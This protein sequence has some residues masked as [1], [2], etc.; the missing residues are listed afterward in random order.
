V[1][2]HDNI[3]PS[4]IFLKSEV[5]ART[6]SCSQ[7]RWKKSAG[8]EKCESSKLERKKHKFALFPPFAATLWKPGSR[9]QIHLS[10]GKS[11]VLSKVYAC[12]CCMSLLHVPVA[13]HCCM[14]LRHVSAAFPCCLFMLHVCSEF[15]CFMSMLHV[16][17]SC[18]CCMSLH[19]H[20]ARPCGKS[21]LHEYA[22]C[23]L[24]ISM[25]YICPCRISIQQVH[26]YAACHSWM[27]IPCFMS[28]LHVLAAFPCS[29]S[30]LYVHA[31]C[32]RCMSQLHVSATCS[33][34]LSILHVHIAYSCY[35]S[36]LHIHSCCISKGVC[37]C[38]NVQSSCQ[39]CF[40]M[41]H[42]SGAHSCNMYEVWS[43]KNVQGKIS[44]IWC[45][46]KSFCKNNYYGDCYFPSDISREWPSPI[47]S[48]PGTANH[49]N[50]SP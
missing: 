15:L 14:A 19:I 33:C 34:C 23:P 36:L 48:L 18:P 12:P 17:V 28:I 37:Q 47:S 11:R 29:M 35:M 20:A 39:C 5:G 46:L 10:R 7:A 32:P 31:E 6:F 30:M 50:S 4:K 40:S 3:F 42:G 1:S 25:L 43:E 16:Q 49:I 44:S 26:I 8:A 38:V 21:M 24:Y 27:S 9:V 2:L 41:L 22:S 13:G 45:N